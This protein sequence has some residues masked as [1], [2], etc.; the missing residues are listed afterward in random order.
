MPPNRGRE[1]EQNL[2]RLARGER[3]DHYETQRQRKD[4]TLIDVSMSHSPLRDRDGALTAVAV[5]ARDITAQR[6]AQE[7]LFQNE[8]ELADF[9]ENAA[10]GLHWVNGEGLILRANRAELELLGYAAEEYVGQHI[11]GFHAD[12]DTIE[13]ILAR[14]KKG[15]SIIEYPARLRCKDGSIK[16]VLIDSSVLWQGGE[17]IH[18]RCFTRDV[19]DRRRAERTAQFLVEASEAL[20]SVIDLRSTLEKVTHLAVPRFA[21]WCCVKLI[22]ANQ[23][24][25]SL[26]MS[27]IDPARLAAARKLFERAP[28][29]FTTAHPRLQIMHGG[30]PQLV[31]EIGDDWLAA[32]FPHAEHCAL[33]KGFGLRSYL[34]VP[35]VIRE[36]KLGLLEF[37]SAESGRSF[38]ARDVQAA[39]DL[40]RRTAV[41]IEN[42]ELYQALRDADRKKDDFLALLAHELRNPL[43]PIQSALQI[44]KVPTVDPRTSGEA[45]EVAERQVVHL[46]RLVD[47]LL[48]VSRIMRGKIVLRKERVDLSAIV[49]R[50]V[51][52]IRPAIDAER[53][54]LSIELPAE[55]VALDADIVRMSQALA[56]LLSN[57]AKYTPAGGRIWLTA[58]LD[59]SL[60]TVR[61]RDTGI[62]IAPET[63]PHLFDMFMQVAP[64][65]TRSQGGLGIGLTL[66]KS[67]IEM[68]GGTVAVQSE[69]LG[70]GSEFSLRLPAP[71]LKAQASAE[72]AQEKTEAPIASRRL[73]IVDDNV[74]AAQSLAVLLRL[75]GHQV[76]VAHGGEE[77]LAAVAAERPEL[78]LLDIGM[79][80]MN[81]YEVAS[82]LRKQFTPEQLT[83]V[84]LTGWGQ[85]QDRR[86]SKEAGF[87]HHLTKPVELATLRKVLAS[88]AEG[89]PA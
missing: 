42:A 70:R 64:G 15:E 58:A 43:A 88:R 67:L 32:A 82:H 18:T 62:G 6:E 35:L 60:L 1:V 79:P 55:E 26:V 8:R 3:I 10:I 21:D 66:V 17:F 29:D 7:K 23:S 49:N 38:D 75:Y 33:V 51:E 81:G 48:D 2:T 4:G 68:H 53:H 61:V 39:E 74:D 76:R 57:A 20:A 44:L 40:A 34:G 27:H 80:G 73:L 59:D 14:L 30:V 9:F 36:R 78:I 89:V 45:R 71:T 83:L 65:T 87:D 31:Q 63:L 85:E 11:A 5:I 69:G 12:A 24:L 28:P 19:T 86:R 13:D 37:F 72:P 16:E 52:T 47:D 22:D 84:A 46:T 77:A 41:A 54:E 56:N 50:A 25:A